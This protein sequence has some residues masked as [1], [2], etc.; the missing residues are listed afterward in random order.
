MDGANGQ[1][2]SGMELNGGMGDD[3]QGQE[4]HLG[5]MTAE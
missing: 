2:T 3:G 1:L 5:D 4:M